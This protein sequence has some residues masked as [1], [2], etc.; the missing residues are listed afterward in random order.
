MESPDKQHIQNNGFE[1]PNQALRRQD[2]NEREILL[3]SAGSTRYPDRTDKQHATSKKQQRND[4]NR[5]TGRKCGGMTGYADDTLRG[6]DSR[7][8]ADGVFRMVASQTCFIGLFHDHVM[9]LLL[10]GGIGPSSSHPT[11]N[12]LSDR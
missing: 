8:R 3:F 6:E 5:I 1:N 12:R 9:D 4:G 7:R 11:G 2:R 10:P